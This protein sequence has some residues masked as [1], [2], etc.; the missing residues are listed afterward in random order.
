[1]ENKLKGK[2]VFFPEGTTDSYEIDI[3]E[4]MHGVKPTLFSRFV[5]WLNS[6]RKDPTP[7]LTRSEAPMV[8]DI[9][10]QICDKLEEMFSTAVWYSREEMFEDAKPAYIMDVYVKEY[11]DGWEPVVKLASSSGTPREISLVELITYY[12]PLAPDE[13]SFHS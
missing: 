5:A 13:E 4:L 12:C 10:T 3:Q 6:L 2:I 9:P 8:V 1:M 7:P 11:H